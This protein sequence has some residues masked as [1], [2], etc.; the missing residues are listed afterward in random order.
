MSADLELSSATLVTI[1]EGP[2]SVVSKVVDGNDR[3]GELAVKT[4]TIHRKFVRE[5]HDIIKEARILKS[6]SHPNIINVLGDVADARAETLSYWMPYLPFSLPNLLASSMFSPHPLVSLFTPSPS[7]P[8]SPRE[9]KFVVLARSLIFQLCAALAYLHDE[10]KIA[11]RDVKPHN[12]M[13][14]ANGKVVLIDFGIAYPEDEDASAKGSDL[15][16]E[17]K[18]KMYFEVSTGPYRAPELLFGPRTYSAPATDL[19]SLGTTLAE[20]FTPLRLVPSSHSSSDD[21]PVGRPHISDPQLRMDGA[22]PPEPFVIPPTM[23]VGDPSA[24]WVRA[25]LFD[26]AR[27]EIGLA[28]SI[29]KTRGSPTEESWPSFLSLPDANKISFVDAHP[30]PLSSLLP[31]LPPSLRALHDPS[32]L[33]T[34]S[35]APKPLADAAATPLDLLHRLLVYEPSRR[36]CAHDALHHPWLADKTGVLLPEGYK[37]AAGTAIYTWADP[38]ARDQESRERTLG[39]LIASMK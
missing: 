13:M 39:D 9:Q 15:W 31:H 30:I 32:S 26:G 29:F 10:V 17:T 38:V 7:D 16:P 5:P 33:D 18:D 21:E 27:G 2:V 12:I 35:H 4:S 28:W 11:H 34:T 22:K 36:L 8:P 19:W 3:R 14:D 1:E 23:R 24:R 25:S 6:L 37:P 20:F